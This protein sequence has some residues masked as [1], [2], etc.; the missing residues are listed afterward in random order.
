[1]LFVV[2]ETDMYTFL[3]ELFSFLTNEPISEDS[4]RKFCVYNYCNKTLSSIE[5]CLPISLDIKEVVMNFL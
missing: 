5:I 4:S 3:V 1:M 2:K